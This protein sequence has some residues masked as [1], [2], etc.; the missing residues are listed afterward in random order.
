MRLGNDWVTKNETKPKRH[1]Y[2]YMYIA[3]SLFCLFVT[4]G[5]IAL[6]LLYK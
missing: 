2:N 6:I 4:F 3:T 5:T 1:R